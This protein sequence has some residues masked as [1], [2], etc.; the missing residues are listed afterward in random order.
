M[1]RFIYDKENLRFK[2]EKRGVAGVLWSI[3]KYI[4]LSF[5]V[6]VGIY[7]IFALVYDTG[8]EKMLLRENRELMA[9][10]DQMNARMD[11]MGKAVENLD[12]RDREIYNDV[13]NTDPPEFG[14]VPDDSTTDLRNLY[15]LHD[16]ALIDDAH[17]KVLSLEQDV[18]S[19]NS[20]LAL[21][22]E[23]FS[24]SAT[25]RRF[26]PSIVPI[27][28][29]KSA[30][31]GA[32]TGKKVNPFFKSIRE[33][34]GIDLLA[35][36]GTE[37]LCT[38]DGSV[39]GIDKSKK[40]FGNRVTVTHDGGYVTTYSH[41]S[42]ISVSKGQR[43]SRGM[44]IGRVG[45]SGTTFVPCLHYEVIRNER[46]QNPVYFFFADLSPAESQEILMMAMNTGQSMD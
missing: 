35:P 19:V 17:E 12:L 7:V 1:A 11:I 15:S 2:L 29:F 4:L 39:T 13:F 44:V 8:R 25:V 46:Y 32:S 45:V 23:K 14:F 41:L 31:T 30:Q 37:V 42:S 26:I 5:V 34:T 3:V 10:L 9:Q 16:K 27:K 38:A 33:H 40:G 24:K 18:A 21:L 28:D 43:V 36:V 6:A 22:A 20:S